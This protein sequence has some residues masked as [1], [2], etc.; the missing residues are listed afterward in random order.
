M[1][2]IFGINPVKEAL[3]NKLEV[4]KL[5]IAKGKQHNAIH[6]IVTLAKEMKIPIQEV[7][8]KAIEKRFPNK[9]HQGVYL[10]VAEIA[11]VEVDEILAFA[12]SKNEEPFLV[13]LDEIEDPH[14]LGAIIRN[15]EA[16]GA[17]GIIIPKRRSALATE[18]VAK[19]SAGAISMV[20]I[21]RVSNLVQTMADLK[22]KGVWICGT[23]LKGQVLHEANLSGAIAVV[24]GNEGK[25]MR[26]L[27]KKS[28]D[29][30]VTIPMKGQINSLNASV[31]TGIILAEVMKTRL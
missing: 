10:T 7:D 1:S 5:F 30:T 31:A 22:S 19:A 28:C 24:I 27:V 26:D 23:D 13:L 14:N 16:F 21:A 18:V 12:Q 3:K 6:S 9:N 8:R 17:H 2:E 4:N 11:Y 15:V 29:F 20:K 25:G